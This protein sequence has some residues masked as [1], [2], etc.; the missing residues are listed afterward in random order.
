MMSTFLIIII[1]K[2]ANMILHQNTPTSSA[3]Q[4]RT[5]TI[6]PNHLFQQTF[7]KISTR[8][9]V[10]PFFYY[11]T[12]S[13]NSKADLSVKST[14]GPAQRLFFCYWT[15]SSKLL[16]IQQKFYWTSSRT[17]DLGQYYPILYLFT[18]L[19]KQKFMKTHLDS[20]VVGH[21]FAKAQKQEKHIG[22]I[23]DC[24]W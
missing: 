1:Y 14:E 20:F 18:K 4:Q 7:S 3:N 19:E 9:P 5:Y 16:D 8:R 11:W 24:Q 13:R 15:S 17:D 10:E 6:G 12:S 23:I 22:Q 21:H 2:D